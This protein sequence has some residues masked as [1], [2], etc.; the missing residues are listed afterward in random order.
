[1]QN[2]KSLYS[3]E[4]EITIQDGLWQKWAP[5]RCYVT[6]DTYRLVHHLRHLIP[7]VYERYR[8]YSNCIRQYQVNST[9]QKRKR[10]YAHPQNTCRFQPSMF[11]GAP[12][13]PMF[14]Y[15]HLPA[16]CILP[17]LSRQYNMF[18]Y[19]IHIHVCTFYLYIH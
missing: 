18:A 7:Y 12:I 13:H 10:C 14:Q 9:E 3:P 17:K 11:K 2:C 4:E 6:A 5:H 1:M 16:Q 19:N 8:Q 15:Q